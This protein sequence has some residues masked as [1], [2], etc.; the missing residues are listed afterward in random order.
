[1]IVL[2]SDDETLFETVELAI[3]RAVP[4]RRETDAQSYLS[5]SDNPFHHPTAIIVDCRCD[6]YPPLEVIDRVLQQLRSVPVLA[7]GW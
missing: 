7:V 2:F 5:S 4:V 3:D 1:M 6:S